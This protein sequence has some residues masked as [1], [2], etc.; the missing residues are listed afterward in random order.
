MFLGCTLIIFQAMNPILASALMPGWG[1]ALS[2]RKNQARAF[3]LVEGTLWTAY[4]GFK[5][6]GHK[7]ESSSRAFAVA[8]CGAN[9]QAPDD[10]YFD[11]LEDYPSSDDYNLEIERN[12]SIYYPDDLER[13][14]EYIREN[15]YF[16]EDAWQWDTSANRTQYWQTRRT[17]REHLQRASFMTG[18]ALVNRLVS[19]LNVA[20]FKA[21]DKFG[22]ETRDNAVGLYF[23]FQ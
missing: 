16:G 5:F 17:A 1:E 23:R 12:A 7:L 9:P 21:E 6:A 22:L 8:H 19:V 3:F 20:L 13:Q 2:G 18:F 4:A 14:Q 15:G 10:D 11:V